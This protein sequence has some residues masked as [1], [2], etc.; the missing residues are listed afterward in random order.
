MT[1]Q[2]YIRPHVIDLILSSELD[3]NPPSVV[4]PENPK[5]QIRSRS[6]KVGKRIFLQH[7]YNTIA[8]GMYARPAARTIDHPVDQSPSLTVSIHS[9]LARSPARSPALTFPVATVPLES[10]IMFQ[11]GCCIIDSSCHSLP[12]SLTPRYLHPRV[13]FCP[14]L[15]LWDL[16]IW[17]PLVKSTDVSG[18][19]SRP[20]L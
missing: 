5:K 11:L 17:E 12:H 9:S 4:S 13:H 6:Q 16:I 10:C 20:R 15:P 3:R 1:W 2:I 18:V 8:H 7:I 19:T 14:S